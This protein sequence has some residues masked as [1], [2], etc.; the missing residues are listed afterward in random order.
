MKLTG[1][2]V[3]CSVWFGP[4]RSSPN[5]LRSQLGLLSAL[6][7]KTC[8]ATRT[9]IATP[10]F[11]FSKFFAADSRRRTKLSEFLTPFLVRG[12]TDMLVGPSETPGEMKREFF[13]TPQVAY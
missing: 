8:S 4:H 11:E 13:R 6:R 9:G 3:W 5:D 7:D 10:R 1:Q 12:K 2:A